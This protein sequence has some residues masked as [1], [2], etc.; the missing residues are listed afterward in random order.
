MALET[1][2]GTAAALTTPFTNLLGINWARDGAGKARPASTGGAGALFKYAGA[3]LGVPIIVEFGAIGGGDDYEGVATH[4]AGSNS[5]DADWY[6][7]EIPLGSS[8]INLNRF[9]DGGYIETVTAFNTPGSVNQAVGDRLRVTPT[10]VSGDPR[11][12]I[13]YWDASAG[14][15]AW[16]NVT[17]Y[18]DTATATPPAGTES[19]AFAYAGTAIASC[20]LESFEAVGVGGAETLDASLAEGV[21]VGDTVSAVLV[22]GADVLQASVSEGADIG[23]SV[24]ATLVPGTEV[25]QASATEG[26]ELGDT[27]SAALQHGATLQASLTEG[28]VVGKRLALGRVVDY[29][30]EGVEL[31]DTV[32]AALT[33]GATLQGDVTEGAE[34]GDTATATLIPATE[35]LQASVEEGVELGD[36]SSAVLVPGIPGELHAALAEGLELGDGVEAAL[37]HGASLAALA[38][39]GVRIGDSLTVSLIH[40]AALAADLSEGFELGDTVAVVRDPVDELLQAVAEEGAS[41]GDTYSARIAQPTADLVSISRPLKFTRTISRPMRF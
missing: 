40:G 36:A 37:Q 22:P 35:S 29:P 10:V 17:T 7:I 6:S 14:T 27:V 21:E 20:S 1:F 8:Q 19:G 33:H 18:T 9:Q 4:I 13:D 28:I 11:W 23:D 25:L 30:A 24:A 38:E 12:V 2:D 32:S 16:V 15:P 41:I 34:L 5:S 31:G 26:V 39:E 3:V